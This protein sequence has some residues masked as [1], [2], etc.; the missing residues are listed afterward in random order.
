VLP[1]AAPA[2][3][4]LSLWAVAFIALAAIAPLSAAQAPGGVV[5]IKLDGSSALTIGAA[6]ITVIHGNV[7]YTDSVPAG[8]GT[9]TVA[10]TAPDGW[11]AAFE[12]ASAFRLNPGQTAPI[13]IT[14]TAPP[15]NSG[16]KTGNL[17][18]KA[19]GDS[20][21]GRTAPP[22]ATATV[23]L[24]RDDPLPPPPPPDRTPL[25]IGIAAGVLVVIGG[26]VAIVAVRKRI[27]REA[28]EA[29]AA[30]RAAYV[31]RETGISIQSVDGPLPFGDR[32]ASIYRVRVE[33]VSD[34]PRIAVIE[35]RERPPT[36]RVAP[37]IP[38]IPLSPGE[39]VVVSVFVNP[40]DGV[41]VGEQARIVVSARPEEAQEKFEPLVIDATATMVRIPEPG[42]PKT[43]VHP[44]EGITSRS[45]TLRF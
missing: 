26:I 9:V 43:V 22:V 28:A 11:K 42:K 41:P 20:G 29:A 13:T 44:R 19:T 31:A 36:W 10:A 12:P 35:V 7:T 30:Q 39:K 37:S 24:T 27:A 33:N 40:D 2:S 15:A 6:N 38:R 17:D 4:A 21:A 18:V 8:Q 1:L 5:T 34:R 3:T 45:M 25:Y 23:A 16:S 32:R 14:L